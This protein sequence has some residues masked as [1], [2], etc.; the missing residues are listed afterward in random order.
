MN[1]II[2]NFEEPTAGIIN[3]NIEAFVSVLIYYF[4]V[5]QPLWKIL[6]K[7]IEPLIEIYDIKDP[8]KNR[9][10]TKRYISI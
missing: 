6:K 4:R 10:D 5:F 9:Y 8:Y 1:N 2:M 7:F 3:L